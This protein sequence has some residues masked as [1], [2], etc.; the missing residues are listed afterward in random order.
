MERLRLAT[1]EEVEKIKAVANLDETSIVLALTTQ[2]GVPLAVVRTVVE[3]DPVVHPEG[4][5]PRLKA[6]FQRDI[7]TFLSAKGIPSYFFNVH[8]DNTEMLSVA[9]TLGGFRQSTAPEFRYQ[10]KL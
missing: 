2:A 8:T 10:V 3:V 9:E 7:E 6:I 4:M 1:P 5:S